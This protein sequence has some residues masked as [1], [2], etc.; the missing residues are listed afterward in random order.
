VNYPTFR[1]LLRE[2]CESP[3]FQG[4]RAERIDE[5]VRPFDEHFKDR[6]P[7]ETAG[8]PRYRSHGLG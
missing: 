7:V 6:T 5:L 8:Q 2:L 4:E 3:V 1:R